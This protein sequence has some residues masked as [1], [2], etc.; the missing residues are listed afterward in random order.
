MA[1]TTDLI[2]AVYANM[3]ASSY[4]SPMANLVRWAALFLVA[5][6]GWAQ[7]PGAPPLTIV[8]NKLPPASLWSPYGKEHGYG[9][10]LQAEGGVGP[11]HWRIVSGSLPR[12]MKLDE[13]SGMISGSSE[14]T[15]QFEFSILLADN[16]QSVNRKYTLTVETPL[17]ISWDNKATVNGD[18]IDGSVKVSNQTGRDFDLTFIVLAVND[19][20]RATAIG[21]QHFRLKRE[22]RDL[23][24]RFG[25]TLSP[26]N[27]VINV[28]VVGEEPISVQ[29]FRARLATGKE[30]IA[31][32]P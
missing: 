15:G 18:R 23:Q 25:D 19:I 30:S 22:T 21:Y 12:G 8:T 31:E 4:N 7:S 3:N 1:A 10:Y 2:P 14:Q 20:G 26:G 28:D 6:A 24:L 16:V 27:Y 5:A 29:I 11:H 17:T 32:A 13:A 9:F